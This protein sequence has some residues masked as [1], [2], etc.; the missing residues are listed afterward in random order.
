MKCGHTVFISVLIQYKYPFHRQRDQL[1]ILVLACL[2]K[3]GTT[4]VS[5]MYMK[6]FCYYFRDALHVITVRLRVHKHKQQWL[7][8]KEWLFG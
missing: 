1:R 2:C 8:N 6:M 4:L 7:N 5:I 3:V